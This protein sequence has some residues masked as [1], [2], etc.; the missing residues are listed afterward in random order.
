VATTIT[1][2]ATIAEFSYTPTTWINTSHIARRPLFL[3]ITLGLT[4]GPTFCITIAESRTWNQTVPLILGIVQFFISV[5]ATLVFAVVPSGRMSGVRVASKSRK[6]LARQ[7]FMASYPS[8]TTKQ[9]SPSVFLWFLAFGCK[10]TEFYWFLTLSFRESTGV[11]FGTK[12][13]S[14]N[15]EFFGNALCRNQVTFTLTIMYLM[16]LVLFFL[17]TLLWWIIWNAILSITR[18][19]CLGLSIW[20][21]WREIY[22]PLP[23]R[24]CSKLLAISDLEIKYKPKV[25]AILATRNSIRSTNSPL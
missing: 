15:D 10:P 1:I 19:F 9:R 4:A 7:T 6:Y 3:L 12:V 22:T 21:S 13:H 24:I 20:T 16:D 17:N 14:C 18:S 2:A 8:M 25:R 23:K 5:A 11:T